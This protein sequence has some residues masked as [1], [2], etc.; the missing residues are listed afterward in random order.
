MLIDFLLRLAALPGA[1]PLVIS[2]MLAVLIV[3]VIVATQG[4]GP[5]GRDPE[6]AP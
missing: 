4:H 2:P 3:V 6:D 1:E 5:R